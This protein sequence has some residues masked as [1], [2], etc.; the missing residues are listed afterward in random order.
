MSKAANPGELRTP[1][2]FMSHVK[3]IDDE[4]DHHDSLVNVFGENVA[5]RC[6][7]VNAHGTEA[8][9]ALKLQLREPAT[10]TCR[11]SPLINRTLDVLKGTDPDPY[12]IVSIDNVQEQ[13]MWLEIKVQR[14]EAA[15]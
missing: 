4:G 15:R 9:E 5:V 3:T 1:V 6:K 8:F 10:I 11:Y 2:Y 7:W 12:E 13:G 14:K